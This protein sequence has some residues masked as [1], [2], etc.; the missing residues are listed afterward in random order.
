MRSSTTDIAA[1]TF[2]LLSVLAFYVQTGPL[3]SAARDYPIGLL[4]A[5]LLGGLFLLIKGLRKRWSDSDPIPENTESVA[6]GRVIFILAASVVY[7]V[8]TSMIGFYPASV[9]FLFG[10][11]IALG[12]V[13]ASGG[14]KK[15]ALAATI[16]TAIMCV[17]VW[18]V[19]V[20][21]LYVPTPEGSLFFR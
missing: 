5:I 18:I 14:W 8:L 9:L 16:F 19:F 21:F 20:E 13:K 6:C 10:S 11:G 3:V 7:V 1:G 4:F 2:C 17:S 12:D 15:L